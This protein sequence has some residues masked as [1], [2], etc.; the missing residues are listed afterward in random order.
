MKTIQLTDEQL[1][2]LTGGESKTSAKFTKE[3]EGIQKQLK[4]VLAQVDALLNNE[5]VAKPVK[6]KLS[7]EELTKLLA[8]GKTQTAIAKEFGYSVGAINGRA[9]KLKKSDKK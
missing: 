7:D 5:E 2:L 1:K 8:E 4:A 6:K 3:L 9:G